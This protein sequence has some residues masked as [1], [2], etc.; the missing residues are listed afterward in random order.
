MKVIIKNLCCIAVVGFLLPFYVVVAAQ[1]DTQGIIDPE[2]RKWQ[3]ENEKRIQNNQNSNTPFTP[4]DD[5]DKAAENN[6]RKSLEGDAGF[7]HKIISIHFEGQWT[8]KPLE[9]NKNINR[10]FGNKCITVNDIEDILTK[11]NAMYLERGYTT[12][13]ALLPAQDLSTQTLT[14]AI[15][16]G[17]IEKVVQKEEGN[18]INLALI[19]EKLE[20]KILNLREIEQALDQYNRIRSNAVEMSIIP[21]TKTG[22]SIIEIFNKKTGNVVNA[23]FS[24]DN[25]GSKSTGE[26]RLGATINL[27]NLLGLN[28]NILLGARR[29][30]NFNPKGFSNSYNAAITLP[31]LFSTLTLSVDQ[32]EYL[33]TLVPVS[34]REITSEGNANSV[35]LSFN[36]SLFRDRVT[37]VNNSIIISTSE[38]KNYIEGLLLTTSS[39]KYAKIINDL[40]L[41]SRIGS[42]SVNASLKYIRGVPW[43][44]SYEDNSG[45]SDKDPHAQFSKWQL[46]IG[47]QL[48][49]AIAN[50]PVNLSTSF[51]VHYADVALYG[52]NQVS[53]GVGTVRGFDTL[54]FSGERGYYSANDISLPFSF[55]TADIQWNG[56][57]YLGV[58]FG[59]I[60]N[61][62]D[63]VNDDQ[64]LIGL[65]AGLRMS[66]NFGI[67]VD[68]SI[69]KP[70][71]YPNKYKK[72]N[73]RFQG[74][75]SLGF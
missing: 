22:Y 5:V 10:L 42:G 37:R 58:D 11:T 12:T 73:P 6:E 50:Q 17:L 60:R 55:S 72:D 33:N 9:I 56:S 3:I 4:K 44:D 2:F 71:K 68:M 59:S 20:N 7:C 41:D 47:Y 34:G 63:P 67:N 46:D 66:N 27:N 14:I 61:I 49:L 13:K 1:T 53:V 23:T 54:S 19:A 45:I 8:V 21:G 57:G 18:Q 70:Y 51:S 28:E 36:K 62:A 65:A 52:A 32:S 29:P 35:S 15:Q 69:G 64:T 26:N 16:E 39:R 43:F 38:S 40:S 74:S 48:S 75:V 25:K 24:L 31:F 30:L